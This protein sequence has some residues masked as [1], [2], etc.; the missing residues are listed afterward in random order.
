MKR[1]PTFNTHPS[2][3][4]SIILIPF[5]AI[6]LKLSDLRVPLIFVGSFVEL[7]LFS[8]CTNV[9]KN[10]MLVLWDVVVA[11]LST[12]KAEIW[13]FGLPTSTSATISWMPPVPITRVLLI[14]VT[15]LRCLV[16]VIHAVALGGNHHF[17]SRNILLFH[18]TSLESHVPSRSLT[19][20][21]EAHAQK[22]P[23]PLK[24]YRT[25]NCSTTVEEFPRRV[26]SIFGTFC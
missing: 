3:L 26:K 8:V 17:V 25:F 15:V 11:L 14:S 23:R 10:C 7:R 20:S 13:T 6:V 18:I 5:S 22:T 21:S 2:P 12:L 19:Q 9:F 1:S 16:W 4:S 24:N